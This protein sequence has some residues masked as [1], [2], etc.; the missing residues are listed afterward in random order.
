MDGRRPMVLILCAGA[1]AAGVFVVLGIVGTAHASGRSSLT[2]RAR[3]FTQALEA[4]AVDARDLEDFLAPGVSIRDVRVLEALRTLRGTLREGSLVSE[5]RTTGG[6]LGETDVLVLSPARP[7]AVAGK[8]TFAWSRTA[9]GIWV[10]DPV[11]R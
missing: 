3:A 8:L 1:L 6:T 5:V 4:S 9:G 2:Q 10:L 7:G 11:A